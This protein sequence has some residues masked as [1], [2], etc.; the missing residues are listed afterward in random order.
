MNRSKG[1][2]CGATR[3]LAPEVAGAEMFAAGRKER[4]GYE[5]MRT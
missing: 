5:E 2:A 4:A 3:R 1:T